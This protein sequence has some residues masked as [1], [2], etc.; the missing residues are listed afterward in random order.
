MLFTTALTFPGA[1]RFLFGARRYTRQVTTSLKVNMPNIFVC[2]FVFGCAG[3]MA[4]ITVGPF[5]LLFVGIPNAV[6]ARE[7]RELEEKQLR[8]AAARQAERD[9]FAALVVAPE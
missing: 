7:R 9:A 5:Y 3:I 2:A 1:A 4:A 8:E 6:K